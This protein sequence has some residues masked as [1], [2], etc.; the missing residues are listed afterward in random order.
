MPRSLPGRKAANCTSGNTDVGTWLERWVPRWKGAPRPQAGVK[1]RRR[2]QGL[3]TSKGA[4]C[5]LCQD[6]GHAAAYRHLRC[7]VVTV[8]AGFNPSV[9]QSVAESGWQRIWISLVF[10]TCPQRVLLCVSAVAACLT[11]SGNALTLPLI[12]HRRIPF[13]D[14]REPSQHKIISAWLF[15][16]LNRHVNCLGEWNA[17]YW[18]T[19]QTQDLQRSR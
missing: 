12:F 7:P 13:L 16:N 14:G 6:G 19:G 11:L 2:S 8:A 9:T 17:G 1:L 3:D 15:S 5:Y 10:Q 18:A 4:V